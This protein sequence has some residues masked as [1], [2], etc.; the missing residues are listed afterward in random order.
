MA[1]ITT[2]VFDI[3]GVLADFCWEDFFRSKVHDEAMVQRLGKASVRSEAW[4]EFDRGVLDTKG[5]VDGFVK[6]DPE[7][8]DTIREVFADLTGLL[9]K[10]EHTIPWI[11]AIKE[12]GYKVLVLSNFSKQA[13][14]A[15]PFM[16]EFLDEVDGG[17]LSY[18]DKIIKPDPAI[19]QL[20]VDRNGLKPQECVFIDDTEKNIVAAKAF[21]MSGIVF[22]DYDQ[23]EAELA[24]LGVNY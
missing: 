22:H 5:I 3:G 2:V 19:Y 6:N 8:E 23:V 14:D 20:L 16:K 1:D 7:I 10:R 12:A 11:R 18:K 24:A 17:I 13:Y 21:G 4:N 15:N 9:K